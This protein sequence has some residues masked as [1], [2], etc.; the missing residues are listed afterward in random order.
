MADSQYFK[1]DEDVELASVVLRLT[2]NSVLVH[3]IKKF[4]LKTGVMTD[5]G[6]AVQ[7]LIHRLK[8]RDFLIGGRYQMPVYR[9][10]VPEEI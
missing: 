4:D 8:S 3:D 2:D 7:P 6:F 10:K 1:Q 5:Y 9:G